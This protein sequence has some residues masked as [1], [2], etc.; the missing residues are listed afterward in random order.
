MFNLLFQKKTQLY[1]KIY[2]YSTKYVKVRIA[3]LKMELLCILMM[4]MNMINASKYQKISK[5]N[6]II[7][8]QSCLNSIF[9]TLRICIGFFSNLIFAFRLWRA[10]QNINL[11]S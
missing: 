3:Q 11:I 5:T 2:G 9:K 7:Y 1:L 8:K 10:K 4:K 6:L